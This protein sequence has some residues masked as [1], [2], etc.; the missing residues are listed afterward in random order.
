MLVTHYAS[1]LEPTAA[2]CEAA[3]ERV[4]NDLTVEMA[5]TS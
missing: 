1:M 5:P 2:L 4:A 3:N